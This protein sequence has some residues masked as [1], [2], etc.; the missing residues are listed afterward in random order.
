MGS[1]AVFSSL[2]FGKGI[3]Y[4]KIMGSKNVRGTVVLTKKCQGKCQ[5]EGS[6]DNSIKY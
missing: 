4:L 1:L 6:S 3:N 2:R 5:G